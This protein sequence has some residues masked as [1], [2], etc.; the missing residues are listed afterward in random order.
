MLKSGK[1]IVH[2]F[3]VRAEPARMSILVR[4]CKLAGTVAAPPNDNIQVGAKPRKVP[5]FVKQLLNK[6]V[7]DAAV[8]I[9]S[10]IS[11]RM[12][13]AVC[14][15]V[16]RVWG[17]CE[18]ID[19]WEARFL[20]YRLVEYPDQADGSFRR[21]RLSPERVARP[22]PQSVMGQIVGSKA[23]LHVVGIARR[24]IV[25]II[26]RPAT[27]RRVI[28]QPQKFRQRQRLHRF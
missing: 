5:Q 25:G 22:S 13:P 4:L 7:L 24:V 26:S 27:I 12:G 10:H 18:Q 21:Y 16:A 9:Q 20:S 17:W 6:R 19:V 23:D 28:I 2:R 8:H 1:Q 14:M 15:I 3:F 11:V